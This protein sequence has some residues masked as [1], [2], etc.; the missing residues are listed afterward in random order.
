MSAVHVPPRLWVVLS[1]DGPDFATN[2]GKQVAHDHINGA[3]DLGNDEAAQ[4]IVREYVPAEQLAALM[5]FAGAVLGDADEADF[6]GD[7][8]GDL[9][10]EEAERSGL[11]QRVQATTP[12]GENCGC[13]EYYGEGEVAECYRMTPLL[14][15]C[16][17]LAESAAKERAS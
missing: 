12:C 11:L 6:A 16:I 10:Q 7:F 9:L 1:H 5:R 2:F 14:Q 4:A 13:V 3:I 15:D 17:A 8:P